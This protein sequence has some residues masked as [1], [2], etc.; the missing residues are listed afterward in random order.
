LQIKATYLPDPNAN[1]AGLRVISMVVAV[2]AARFAPSSRGLIKRKR[3]DKHRAADTT[4]AATPTA[5]V[6]ATSSSVPT[7]AFHYQFQDDNVDVNDKDDVR[8]KQQHQSTTRHRRKPFKAMACLTSL[9]SDLDVLSDWFFYHECLSTDREYFR[10]NH[11][12]LVPVPLL[13]LILTS[14]IFGTI[15]W[16]ILATDGRVAAPVLRILGIDRLSMGL[17]LFLCV[18]LEDIPQ[19]VLTFLIQDYYEEDDHNISSFAILNV[20]ASLY[21]T[22]IKLA[23]AYDE[24]SD[25]VETGVFCK[26]IVPYAHNDTI[27]AILTLPETILGTSTAALDKALLSPMTLPP[28]ALSTLGL[29]TTVEPIKDVASVPEFQFLTASLDGTVKLW[30]SWNG[31]LRAWH[32]HSGV[33]SLAILKNNAITNGPNERR[34]DDHAKSLILAGCRDGSIRAWN[35]ETCSSTEYSKWESGS[36]V[37]SLG[38]VNERFVITGHQDGSVR[39]WEG[40]TSE[41]QTLYSGHKSNVGAIGVVGRTLFVSGSDDGELRLWNTQFASPFQ[42]ED[43]HH[44]SRQR[45]ASSLTNQQSLFR[46]SSEEQST[47]SCFYSAQSHEIR[48]CIANFVGHASSILSVSCLEPE[49]LFVSGS[50]DHTARLW[51][52]HSGSCIHVF[53]EHSAAI[54]SVISMD[55]A[56]FMTAS[57]DASIKVWDVHRGSLRTYAGHTTP[58]TALALSQDETTFVSASQSGSLRFWV[59]TVVTTLERQRSTS[60][61]SL[62]HIL[63]VNDGCCRGIDPD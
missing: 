62:D 15:I 2:L 47:K 24:R 46:V 43:G 28:P 27:T 29:M 42:I 40:M 13:R 25:I 14:C 12:H 6:A 60:E 51:S 54:S 20:T 19:V 11:T 5:A 26:A 55:E 39:L 49:E 37:S 4:S 48:C 38:V 63:D 34:T 23:E 56:T 8:Q 53:S 36:P 35:L 31:C 17:L 58:V 44:L 52:L 33:T 30:D 59:L 45:S 3:S 22:L 61:S 50:R 10:Q 7:S 32:A 1:V 41:I 9:A 16:L 18:L 21:D 57:R